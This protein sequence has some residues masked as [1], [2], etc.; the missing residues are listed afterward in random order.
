MYIIMDQEL[1]LSAEQVYEFQ[2]I[3]CTE[4]FSN[5]KIFRKKNKVTVEGE[6][7]QVVSPQVCL[8]SA[9]NNVHII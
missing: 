7:P 1:Q 5:E 6:F 8:G 4:L 2:M 9:S 3:G